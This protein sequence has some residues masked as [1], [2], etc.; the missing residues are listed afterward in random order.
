L[1]GRAALHARLASLDPEAAARIQ[2]NDLV[3]VV[4]ALEVARGGQTQSALHSAHRFAGDRYRHRL[5]VLDPPR[6]T[7][8]ARIDARVV[9]MFQGGILDEA[10]ALLARPG[11]PPMGRLPLG[12]ADAIEV[13]AGRLLLDEAVRRVQVAHRR[14]A[15]RQVIWLRRE[16]GA[17]PVAPPYDTAALAERLADL[18]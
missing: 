9:A 17:E 2:P 16:R 1:L 15:R 4:R 6:A 18:R 5:L 8:H 11:G 14:Y 13:V 7:L 10:R 12:Y 3:R